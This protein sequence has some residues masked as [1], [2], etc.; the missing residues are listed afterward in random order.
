MSVFR[1][2]IQATLRLY[3]NSSR[4]S[5]EYFIRQ[6]LI[7]N[8]KEH[9]NANTSNNIKRVWKCTCRNNVSQQGNTMV[10]SLCMNNNAGRIL[11]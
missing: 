9:K 10:K 1:S 5:F 11:F 7:K 4:Y 8:E 2:S 3:N 6:H